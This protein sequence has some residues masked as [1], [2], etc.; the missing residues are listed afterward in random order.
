[1]LIKI[2]IF[3]SLVTF[4][5][6]AISNIED[7]SNTKEWKSLLH[8]NSKNEI[9]LPA[10]TFACK[11]KNSTKEITY[12]LENISQENICKYPA[13]YNFLKKNMD[14]NISF[15][16]CRD[17]NNFMNDSMG[18]SAS[19]VF[20][21]SFLS[22]PS[23]FFGHV[24]LKTN[25]K[26]NVFFS[27]TI[28]YAAEVPENTGFF[29]MISSGVSGK[30]EGTITVS[31][32]FK[33][34]ESY[35][36]MEQRNIEEYQLN[37]NKEEVYTMLLHVYEL[38]LEKD[39][40]KFFENNCATELLWLIN[41]AKPNSKI[42]EE[43]SFFDTPYGVVKA[44]KKV[45]LIN[46]NVKVRESFLEK[47]SDIY[48]SMNSK[49]KALFN[50][51][52]NNQNK[53][54]FINNDSAPLESKRKVVNLL[55]M[56]YDFNFKKYRKVEPDYNDVKDLAISYKMIDPEKESVKEKKETKIGTAFSKEKGVGL[57]FS[58]AL[59]D[60]TYDRTNDL[61]EISLEFLDSEF[62]VK[63]G[64]IKL[65][66]L[67]LVNIESYSLITPFQKQPSWRLY[68]G[69]KRN[70]Y[71]EMNMHLEIGAG[72]TIGNDIFKTYFIPQINIESSKDVADIEGLTGASLW[73]KDVH[74]E[75]LFKDGIFLN[76]NDLNLAKISYNNNGLI[77][78]IE[79]DFNKKESLFKV[80]Y[81]F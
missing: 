31:P 74:L 81:S 65:E 14:L 77:F 45:G 12:L 41:V 10:E 1:M 30:F 52:K 35:N 54:E 51:L 80:I 38:L 16:K 78:A 40:Y 79:R 75:Y 55:D 76:K 56:Y 69:L 18:E 67:D 23:S 48:F 58:P 39:H 50:E 28:S 33:L 26:D 72:I 64:N 17:L 73:I 24:F 11:E 62:F 42:M 57:S 59:M 63:D 37:L 32:Y 44:S 8:T 25:K 47:M 29:E 13:K 70:K 60:R 43:K 2:F 15:E 3:L 34:L 53:K 46:E 9:T 5:L 61:S 71:N 49:E 4:N 66:K 68:S 7:L 19:I 6:F 27:Q 20:V 22:S 36:V 21:S